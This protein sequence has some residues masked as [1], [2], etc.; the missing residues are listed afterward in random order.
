MVPK[1]EGMGTPEDTTLDTRRFEG[2]MEFLGYQLRKTS[3]YPIVHSHDKNV[4]KR[5]IA[6]KLERETETTEWFVG[7]PMLTH[8]T[9]TIHFVPKNWLAKLV[10][11]PET[12]EIFTLDYEFPYQSLN[13]S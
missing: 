2:E 11:K 13:L 6:Q 5:E 4:I 3:A 10:P 8:T 7:D 12:R 9:E 1:D